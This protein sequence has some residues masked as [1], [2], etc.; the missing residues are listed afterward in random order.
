MIR[1]K[2]HGSR[3]KLLVVVSVMM[4][5]TVTA[6]SVS[7][8]R[9]YFVYTGGYYSTSTAMASAWVKTLTYNDGYRANYY[10]V[11][12]TEFELVSDIETQELM[13][14]SG[15]GKLGFEVGYQAWLSN[16]KVE[17]WGDSGTGIPSTSLEIVKDGE[18]QNVQVPPGMEITFWTNSPSN[19][20]ES[21]IISAGEK[22]LE[23]F[24]AKDW[25]LGYGF[26]FN[27]YKTVWSIKYTKSCNYYG[28]GAGATIKVIASGAYAYFFRPS[29][30]GIEATAYLP[31]IAWS[32]TDQR[33]TAAYISSE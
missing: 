26:T 13:I 30:L 20:I 6:S 7:G 5:L 21:L 17:Y 11:R 25:C 2:I 1:A 18:V 32:I 3:R 33:S 19:I 12:I 28:S 16:L 27:G 4:M 15:I 14:G 22:I 24:T 10:N 8:A 31:A 23:K 29:F 9:L